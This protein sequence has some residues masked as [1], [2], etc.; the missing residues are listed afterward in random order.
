MMHKPEP[1]TRTETTIAPE[2]KPQCQSDQL[3][4]AATTCVFMGLMVEFEGLEENPAHHPNTG[5]ELLLTFA[6]SFEELD[7]DILLNLQSSSSPLVLPSIKPV[8]SHGAKSMS[9]SLIPPSQPP[10]PTSTS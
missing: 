3:Y 5:G 6:G 10:C 2:P 4:E 8:S 7:L 1:E 9:S